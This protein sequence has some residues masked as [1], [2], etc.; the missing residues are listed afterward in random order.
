MSQNMKIIGVRKII[1]DHWILMRLM[2]VEYRIG[3]RKSIRK[4]MSLTQM[5]CWIANYKETI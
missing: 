4:G 2:K 5:E 3:I 1:E